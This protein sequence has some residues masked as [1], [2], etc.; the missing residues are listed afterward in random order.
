MG[1][2][3]IAYRAR[4]RPT[5]IAR[6]ALFTFIAANTPFGRHVTMIGGNRS[7]VPGRHQVDRLI[8]ITFIPSGAISGLAG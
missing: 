6:Y 5:A 1:I 2:E 8:L 3:T 7:H 4:D